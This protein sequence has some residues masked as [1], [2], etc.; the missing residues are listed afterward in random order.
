MCYSIVGRSAHTGVFAM[1]RWKFAL[2]ALLA[3]G[4]CGGVLRLADMVRAE[5]ELR[6][7]MQARE[8][9]WAETNLDRADSSAA[10]LTATPGPSARPDARRIWQVQ[11]A[12]HRDANGNYSA[13]GLHNGDFR[14]V[15]DQ[16]WWLWS[17]E[18]GSA[19]FLGPNRDKSPCYCSTTSRPDG[20]WR[21]VCDHHHATPAPQVE[22]R[23]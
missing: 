11:G 19:W 9:Y 3:V 13:C 5:G 2:L 1:R 18:S 17:N 15:N 8:A 20:P 10:P 4:M 23:E 22:L 16:S 12:G 14:Y 7:E 21:R 6:E